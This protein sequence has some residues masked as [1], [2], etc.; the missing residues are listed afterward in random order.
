VI[1][2]AQTEFLKSDE[3]DAYFRKLDAGVKAHAQSLGQRQADAVQ[4]L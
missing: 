1:W 4:L 3:G 2:T